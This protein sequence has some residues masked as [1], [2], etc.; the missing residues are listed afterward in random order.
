MNV[1]KIT[2]SKGKTVEQPKNQ[3]KKLEYV[4]ELTLSEKDDVE[5]A[6]QYAEMLLD[7]WLDDSK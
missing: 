5:V 2:I 1:S 3:W 4:I 6:K 7:T